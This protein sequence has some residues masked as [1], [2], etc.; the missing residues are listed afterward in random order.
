VQVRSRATVHQAYQTGC[1]MRL[2]ERPV[3]YRVQKPQVRLT[4]FLFDV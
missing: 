4:S 1:K 3:F 2:N